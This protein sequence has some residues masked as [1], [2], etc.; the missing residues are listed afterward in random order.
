MKKVTT[1]VPFIFESDPVA[2]TDTHEMYLWKYGQWD[3]AKDN[4]IIKGQGS[5]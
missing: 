4:K 5:G 3:D 1:L 2:R